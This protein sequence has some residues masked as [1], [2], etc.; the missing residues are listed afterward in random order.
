MTA[1]DLRDQGKAEPTKEVR[2]RSTARFDRLR[3]FGIAGV[4]LALFVGLSFG[5][6]VFLTSE[7]LKNVA[8]QSVAV[9][10][11]ATAGSLVIIAGGFDLSAGAIFAVSA[12]VG[13]KLA[14]ST[15]I[16]EGY[17]IGILVGALL[18]LINGIICTVGRINHFVGTLAT[19]IVFF[20]VATKISGGALIVVPNQGFSDLANT[21]ILGLKSSTWIFVA[22][23]LLCGFILNFT[24]LGRYI[25]ATG[26]NIQAARLSGVPT[27]VTQAFTYV[28]SGGAAG[29]AGLIVASRT[30]SVNAQ[31]GN[32]IIYNA[33]AA[34][35]IGG[36]S[37]LGG[38]GAIWRTVCGVLI[39]TLIANGFNLLGIDP[40]YQ[41]IVT[42]LI[43]LLAV[44]LDAW[45]RRTRT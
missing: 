19:S 5:S 11:L 28:L 26:G 42:G 18:G 3:D 34:I 33:L 41:Q 25:F 21:Q 23:A 43:I 15:G 44:G 30:L 35:L 27:A 6:S 29:L 1:T 8:E 13:A 14:N 38:E 37:V 45:T 16:V 36:N 22:F 9:G 31:T 40:L 7:N 12:I 20:G 10:L 17:L 2:P 24:V 4:L 32:G 39:L